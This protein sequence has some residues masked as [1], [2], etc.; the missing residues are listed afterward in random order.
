MH[1]LS[2]IIT[3]F[4]CTA[5]ILGLPLS[6][7]GLPGNPGP[8]IMNL[9]CIRLA[10]VFLWFSYGMLP[11]K[12]CCGVFSAISLIYLA[13]AWASL[14]LVQFLVFHYVSTVVS[15]V[16]TW[17]SRL[18]DLP[19]ANTLTLHCWRQ[20]DLLPSLTLSATVEDVQG[21]FNSIAYG[22]NASVRRSLEERLDL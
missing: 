20:M 13:L 8:W 3:F 1:L 21:L 12:Y 2:H 4:G 15:K 19:L 17:E 9:F 7:W 10:C 22:F 14:K 6:W 5:L 18:T 11:L 16:W